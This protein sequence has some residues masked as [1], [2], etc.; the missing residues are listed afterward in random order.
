MTE[1]SAVINKEV[2][3]KKKDSLINR[4]GKGLESTTDRN[5]L[6]LY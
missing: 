1:I 6:K 2:K 5:I 3:K 4:R